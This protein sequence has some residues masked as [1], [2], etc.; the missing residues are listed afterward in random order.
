MLGGYGSFAEAEFSIGIAYYD[1]SNQS[2]KFANGSSTWNAA[3][4]DWSA[5]TVYQDSTNNG[6]YTDVVYDASVSTVHISYFSP[7]GLGTL[8]HITGTW[9]NISQEYQWSSPVEIAGGSSTLR[10]SALTLDPDGRPHVVFRQG[11]AIKHAWAL[12]SAATN[13]WSWT[14]MTVEVIQSGVGSAGGVDLITGAANSLHISFYYDSNPGTLKYAS[15]SYNS[16]N[17]S[18]AWQVESIDGSSSLD[19]G[20]YSAITIDESGMVFIAY[21]DATNGNLKIAH[22]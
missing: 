4:T 19:V 20:E 15:A 21:Y 18:W 3:I 10:Y 17:D 11:G 5:Q 12:W 6:Q 1:V 8:N 9:D 16:V 2:L 13:S 7:T 22:N 14:P